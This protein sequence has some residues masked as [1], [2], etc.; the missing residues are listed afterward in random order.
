MK[1]SCLSLGCIL[2]L[3]CLLILSA[4]K[5]DSIPRAT[6]P[7]THSWQAS[8][9]LAMVFTSA[10]F[11]PPDYAWSVVPSFV[12]YAD[13]RVIVT[14]ESYRTGDTPR[15][16]DEGR[17]DAS[18]MCSL[19]NQIAVDGFLT[20]KQSDYIDPQVTDQGTTQI[21]VN[22]WQT[23]TISAYG[24]GFALYQKDSGVQVPTALKA[25]AERLI[26]YLPANARPYQ[27]D[28]LAVRLAPIDS[29]VAAPL[30][31]LSQSTLTELV[32]KANGTSGV[33]LVEGQAAQDIYSQF[34]GS[35]SKS[36]SE[37]G[38]TYAVTIRPVF[39]YEK[40][41]PEQQ[42]WSPAP[43]F[44]TGPAITLTCSAGM[45]KAETPIPATAVPTVN[46]AT[47][48]NLSEAPLK[49]ITEFG[50]RDSPG[51]LNYPAGLAILPQDELL[52][53]DAGNQRF[54][55]FSLDGKFLREI[56]LPDSKNSFW[57]FQRM[58]DGSYYILEHGDAVKVM[59]PDGQITATFSG[60]PKGE[61]EFLTHLTV[62]PDRTIYLAEVRGKRVVILNADGTLREIW[63]GPEG[64]PFDNIMSLATDTQGNLYVAS[65]DQ[66]RVVK[67]D[68]QGGVHEF[69]LKAP[70]TVLPLPDESFYTLGDGGVTYHDAE[71][72]PL[73]QWK[74]EG[75]W[76]PYYLAR[77]MDGSIFVMD[78]D[79]PDKGKVIR[80]YSPDGKLL[81]QFGSIDDEPGQFGAH[82]DFA[83]SSQGDLWFMETDNGLGHTRVP[84]RLVHISANDDHLN[85]F[86]TLDGQPFA[87][88]HYTLAAGPEQ[89]VFLTDPCASTIAQINAK[90][91]T[92]QRWGQ[93]GTEPGQ[94]N[95]IRSLRLTPDGQ[96]LLVVDEG[97]RRLMQFG[98]DG[99]LQQEWKADAV[100]VQQPIDAALDPAGNFYLLDATT[101]EVV[102]RSPDGQIRKWRVPDSDEGVNTIAIDPTRGRI[103]VGSANTS[104]YV[105][106]LVGKLLG[107][108]GVGGSRGVIVKLDPAGRVYAS[109]GYDH[110]DLFEPT[111]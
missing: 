13:G 79:P 99:R 37:N 96:S 73:Q 92:L 30:W 25:T 31:P 44:A 63:K 23:N 94:F 10:G 98:L 36:Y 76:F 52:V 86:E 53:G 16:I 20:L 35:F 29:Q 9:V 60:W 11:T 69:A 109:T 65:D 15:L 95:L 39:P 4:C 78:D 89:S 22:A 14:R 103:Y 34:A 40:W 7:E 105:Y 49:Q 81:N 57:N 90:G 102:V 72:K 84:T 67:R 55:V 28:R 71:G 104:L 24:L 68:P 58:A 61:D 106:D 111:P 93:K 64:K 82:L 47:C 59:S 8:P 42:G 88:D 1:R 3:F 12:L 2:L 41:P 43:A 45:L 21:T 19:L 48:C 77:A 54:Q 97:N 80:R 74:T 70:R 17:L 5:P 56:P 75:T 83:P 108:E 18:Q 62:G 33:V 32:T 107:N 38:K 110:I 50:R 27:P 6:A 101:Q 66:N 46:P 51:Q 91:K 87:C 85:T 100:G 26:N